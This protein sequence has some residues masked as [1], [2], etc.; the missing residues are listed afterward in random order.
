MITPSFKNGIPRNKGRPNY[1]LKY[2]PN[3]MFMDIWIESYYQNI[4]KDYLNKYK[5]NVDTKKIKS[6]F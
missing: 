4:K 5:S 1:Y 6:R 2:L 3:Y